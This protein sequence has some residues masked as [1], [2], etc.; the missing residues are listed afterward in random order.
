MFSEILIGQ[1]LR[2]SSY[3]VVFRKGVRVP[4]GVPGIGG[5]GPLGLG[6]DGWWGVCF[7]LEKEGKGGGAGEGGRWGGDRQRNRQVNAHAF[8]KTTL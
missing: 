1:K 4:I 7:S 3:G 6:S 2:G 8:A 5:W